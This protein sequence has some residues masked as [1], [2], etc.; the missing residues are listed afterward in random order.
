MRKWST[1]SKA[2]E[3][4]KRMKTKNFLLNCNMAGVDQLNQS[5]FSDRDTKSP[6]GMGKNKNRQT[7]STGSDEIKEKMTIF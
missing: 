4:F 6:I 2:A 7:T 1:V 5:H 3:K